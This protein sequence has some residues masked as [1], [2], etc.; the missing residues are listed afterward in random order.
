VESIATSLPIDAAEDN[1]FAK[2]RE[3][4][5][6]NEALNG[7]ATSLTRELGAEACARD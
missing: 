2:V 6:K 1:D 5:P 4:V 3:L 7:E